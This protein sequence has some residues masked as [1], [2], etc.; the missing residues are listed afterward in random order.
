MFY[1]CRVKADR[2]CRLSHTEI[3]RLLPG[4][5]ELLRK[6]TNTSPNYPPLAEWADILNE[7]D[8]EVLRD[9]AVAAITA[10]GYWGDEMRAGSP[11]IG[12]FSDRERI[13]IINDFRALRGQFTKIPYAEPYLEP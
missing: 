1:K 2:L 12:V 4:W 7:S 3:R 13:D 8:I 6:S 5:K 11:L 10:E 9:R